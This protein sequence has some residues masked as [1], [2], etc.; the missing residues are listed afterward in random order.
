MN[1]DDI[2][3][4]VVRPAL[5]RLNLAALNREQLVVGTGNTESQYVHLDQ[6]TPGPGPAYGPWQMEKLTHDDIWQN[7]ITY[8][9]AALRDEL[10]QI[11]G[12][13][14][15]PPPI[16]TLHW[17]LMYGAAMCAVHYLR[18]ERSRSNPD[19]LPEPGDYEAMAAYWKKWYNTPK[20][21]GTVA[22]ATPFFKKACEL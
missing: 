3:E 6:T 17:N 9:P 11:A 21:K 7:F 2:R 5:L 18:R 10:L 14:Y 13:K 4:F 16:E 22:K 20:G 19:P 12:A 1:L 8:Q 15:G